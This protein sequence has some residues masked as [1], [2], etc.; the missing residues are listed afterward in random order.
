MTTGPT[1]WPPRA[2]TSLLAGVHQYSRKPTSK[3]SLASLKAAL[4][5]SSWNRNA[6]LLYT[7]AP[8]TNG[9]WDIHRPSLK[10]SARPSW[11]RLMRFGASPP[12]MTA[13]TTT[14]KP[15]MKSMPE[16]V[17]GTQRYQSDPRG[18]TKQTGSR[19]HRCPPRARWPRRVG[20]RGGGHPSKTR[21]RDAWL[22]STS[23][24]PKRS[25]PRQKML[26]QQ[27]HSKTARSDDGLPTWTMKRRRGARNGRARCESPPLALA[28][29]GDRGYEHDQDDQLV[30]DGQ[31]L[32]RLEAQRHFDHM[33]CLCRNGNRGCE[34]W[35]PASCSGWIGPTRVLRL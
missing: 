17:R 23:A 1:S 7:V 29:Y 2:P 10:R 35:C 27:Q 30:E 15:G 19:H 25:P 32:A 6:E 14:K 24:L 4:L 31:L 13:T 18:H 16:S 12:T 21:R 28:A 9:P 20:G 3:I 5:H 33:L 34:V 26:R 8:P 22:R 11:R